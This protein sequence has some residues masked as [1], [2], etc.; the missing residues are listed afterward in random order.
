MDRVVILH[1]LRFGM[2]SVMLDLIDDVRMYTYKS[3]A[4]LCIL[5]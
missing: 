5:I 1:W 4:E 3:S 2:S